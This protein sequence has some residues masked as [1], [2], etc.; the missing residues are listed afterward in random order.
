MHAYDPAEMLVLDFR[1]RHVAAM[2]EHIGV[3][4]DA[5]DALSGDG[6]LLMATT[7]PSASKR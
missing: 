6:M 7:R 2:Y 5:A 4:R 1:A 3:E